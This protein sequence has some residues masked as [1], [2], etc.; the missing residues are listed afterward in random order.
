MWFSLMQGRCPIG[1][2]TRGD[3]SIGVNDGVCLVPRYQTRKLEGELGSLGWIGEGCHDTRVE[4]MLD[5][6]VLYIGIVNCPTKLHGS[7][8]FIFRPR[9]SDEPKSSKP[10]SRR[11]VTKGGR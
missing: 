10:S 3:D 5:V 7:W 9:G 11:D 4:G 1:E 2:P 8:V 6:Q